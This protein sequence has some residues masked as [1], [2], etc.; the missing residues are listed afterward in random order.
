MTRAEIM[1]SLTM[2]PHDF[3]LRDPNRMLERIDIVKFSID[4]AEA[5]EKEAKELGLCQAARDL[6]VKAK[7]VREFVSKLLAGE[8]VQFLRESA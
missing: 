7:G 1:K 5:L 6:R 8:H 3:A 4:H 2:H